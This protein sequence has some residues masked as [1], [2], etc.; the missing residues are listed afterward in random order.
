MSDENKILTVS[1][2]TFSCTLEGFDNPFEAMKAIAEYFRDLAAGDRFFGAEPPTPD[3]EMLHRITED[4]IQARVD[5]RIM[6]SGLLLRPSNYHSAD[7]AEPLDAGDVTEAAAPHAVADLTDVEDAVEDHVDASDIAAPQEADAEDQGTGDDVTPLTQE[8]EAGEDDTVDAAAPSEEDAAESIEEDAAPEEDVSADLTD[9]AEAEAAQD[10]PVGEG[11]S[12]SIAAAA[13]LA[14]AALAAAMADPVDAAEDE[15]SDPAAETDDTAGQAGE[16]TL[17]AVMHAMASLSDADTE[18]DSADAPD[19]VSQ[20][21]EEAEDAAASIAAALAGTADAAA[22]QIEDAADAVETSV[23]EMS[24]QVEDTVADLAEQ[25]EDAA[26]DV[27]EAVQDAAEQ[28]AEDS[29]PDPDSVAAKLARIRRVVAQEEDEDAA[30]ATG[31]SEDEDGSD[32]FSDGPAADAAESAA[33]QAVT[34]PQTAAIADRADAP[35]A[36]ASDTGTEAPATPPA[37]ASPARS[38]RVWVIRGRTPDA[39]AEAAPAEP[40]T[41]EPEEDS[42]LA[43][44]AEAELQRELAQIESEREA[45]RAEREARRQHMNGNDV[46]E[47][48]V[49]RLFDATDSRLSTDENT[50]RRAN[51]EHLKAAV[52]AR[53]AEEQL[54]GPQE[55]RDDTA[56]YREDLAQVMRPRR[57][58]NN[59]RRRSDRPANEQPRQTPLVLVSEQRVDEGDN[60]PGPRASVVRPRRI[61]RGNTALARDLQDD[62]DEDQRPPLTLAAQDQVAAVPTPQ[63]NPPEPER[64]FE[65]FLEEQDIDDMNDVASAACGYLAAQPG[66]SVFGR[67]DVI[68]MLQNIP[69][70]TVSREQ[71]ILAFGSVLDSGEIEK[72]RRGQFQL[73]T[74]SPY[75]N[76]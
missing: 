52:A 63:D 5:A 25:A 2:G 74:A 53:A 71:A 47:A 50:R 29:Y 37:E 75:Y 69:G 4:A 54:T 38:P 57:V 24:E 10:A 18:D 67:S 34:E 55:P 45:R 20:I 48:N 27:A 21:A 32:P 6:E 36:P 65:T 43:P 13:A 16:D 59:G 51:I 39:L 42:T 72:I 17:S 58:Q 22:D 33:P 14:G 64:S 68:R 49:S 8:A 31:Y 76:G 40:A 56:Q 30:P 62:H 28:P 44:D 26:E 12:D 23:N 66:Q 7:D 61:A 3:T 60:Q 35:E 15:A 19:A 46:A 70:N 73:T 11:R 1:Y 9:E 41:A